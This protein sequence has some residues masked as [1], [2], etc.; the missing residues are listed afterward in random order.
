MNSGQIIGDF[1]IITPLKKCYQNTLSENTTF[2]CHICEIA[3][4][5]YNFK[6]TIYSS[7]V[8]KFLYLSGKLKKENLKSF[9]HNMYDRYNNNYNIDQ[10]Q[11]SKQWFYPKLTG[12]LQN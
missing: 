3:Y 7:K 11:S 6:T 12:N 8:L 2:C 4:G 10:F 9:T 5:K 1:T